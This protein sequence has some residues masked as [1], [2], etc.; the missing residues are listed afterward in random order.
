[1]VNALIAFSILLLGS[2]LARILLGRGWIN[3]SEFFSDGEFSPT[4]PDFIF[5]EVILSFFLLYIVI[6]GARPIIV[7]I[8]IG[9]AFAYFTRAPIILMFFAIMF[10]PNLGFKN[11]LI[12][13][14]VLLIFTTGILYLRV[15]EGIFDAEV[16]KLFFFTYPFVGIARLIETTASSD[17]NSFHIISVF[18]KPVDVFFFAIDYLA[19][20]QGSLSSTRLVG[21]ELTQFKYLPLLGNSYNAFGTVAFP[22]ILVFGWF[23][24]L[25]FFVIFIVFTYFSYWYYF[26]QHLVSLKLLL[27]ILITG[28]LFTW[29]SPFIWLLPLIFPRSILPRRV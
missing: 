21:A 18:L 25:S 24:G 5:N 10:S 27:M 3:R 15:G 12:L 19:G 22:F 14:A 8:F 2:N 16:F 4:L 29:A 17:V 6:I 1:M 9:S 26:R 23:F 7:M 20:L 28:L 11:K 13:G